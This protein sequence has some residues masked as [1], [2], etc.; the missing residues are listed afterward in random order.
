MQCLYYCCTGVA[1]LEEKS[2]DPETKLSNLESTNAALTLANK[3]LEKDLAD[4]VE[5]EK[6]ASKRLSQDLNKERQRGHTMSMKMDMLS[7]EN[8]KL[9]E[10]L[11]KVLLVY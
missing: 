5:K 1:E 9:A 3:S 6:I 7:N 8:G 10:D 2:S 4:S 11:A